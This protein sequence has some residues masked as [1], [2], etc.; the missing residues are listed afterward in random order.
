LNRFVPHNERFLVTKLVRWNTMTQRATLT[1]EFNMILA[2]ADAILQ[3]MGAAAFVVTAA[4]LVGL[5]G[6]IRGHCNTLL[7]VCASLPTALMA[8]LLF[9][10][11]RLHFSR[12]TEF[13]I[14]TMIQRHELEI[15]YFLVGLF[16]LVRLQRN[17]IRK[18]AQG[19]ASNS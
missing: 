6:S 19:S 18:Q 4:T 12:P 11:V 17:R 5:V 9:D 1:A 7:V 10:V 16:T 15:V 8:F 2:D 13:P 3:I 14:S